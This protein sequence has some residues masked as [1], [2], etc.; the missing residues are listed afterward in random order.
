M[1]KHILLIFSLVLFAGV[2]AQVRFFFG[3]SPE[4]KAE[5]TKG[6]MDKLKRKSEV[7]TFQYT[8]DTITDSILIH[9]VVLMNDDYNSYCILYKM[10]TSRVAIA[11]T[12][13]KAAKGF[14]ITAYWQNRNVKRVSVYD[15]HIKPDSKWEAYYEDRWLKWRGA[16]KSGQKIGKWKYYDDSGNVALIERYKDGTLVK[17]IKK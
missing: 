4:S 13:L 3:P 15:K 6:Q 11:I 14:K 8:G 17:S 10:D 16:Y 1:K 2:N 12:K 7:L 5:E 9:D